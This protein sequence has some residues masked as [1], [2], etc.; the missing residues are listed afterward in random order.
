MKE[1]E[2][3]ENKMN[4]EIVVT[5][6][7]KTPATAISDSPPSRGRGPLRMEYHVDRNQLVSQTKL[8]RHFKLPEERLSLKVTING[9]EERG[10]PDT[11]PSG[12]FQPLWSV[13]SKMS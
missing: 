1:K 8:A 12:G 10:N 6:L 11:S 13:G 5:N 7:R 3:V 9:V 2:I 4:M